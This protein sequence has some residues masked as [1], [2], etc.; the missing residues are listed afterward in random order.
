MWNKSSEKIVGSASFISEVLTLESNVDISN[1]NTVNYVIFRG[2]KFIWKDISRGWQSMRVWGCY[3]LL[4][5]QLLVPEYEA[6]QILNCCSCL[7]L[8]ILVLQLMTAVGRDRRVKPLRYWFRFFPQKLRFFHMFAGALAAN[9][10]AWSRLLWKARKSLQLLEV[11]NSFLPVLFCCLK[12]QCKRKDF[13]LEF[14]E[15]T[16]SWLTLFYIEVNLIYM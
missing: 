3:A 15:N 10:W 1:N 14:L 12:V 16:K 5:A 7:P 2:E 13:K 4:R 9:A 8:G 11:E 6:V